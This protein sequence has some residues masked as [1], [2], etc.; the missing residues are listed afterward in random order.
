MPRPILAILRHPATALLAR[1]ALTSAFWTSG[2][3]KLLDYPGA[4]GEVAGL[5]VPM[6]QLTAALVIAVQLLGSAAIV[7]GRYVWLGAGALA[8]FTMVATVLAHA[9]WLAPAAEAARQTA[10]FMEHMGLIGGLVL[11]S[12]LNER[13]RPR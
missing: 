11:V 1:L 13:Q 12:I 7:S 6:P 8:V 10:T 2:V 5:G 9:F 3:M 4:V